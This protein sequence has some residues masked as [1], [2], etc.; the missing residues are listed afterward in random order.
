M[1]GRFYQPVSFCTFVLT[2][3]LKCAIKCQTKIPKGRQHT[4]FSKKLKNMKNF[5]LCP[6]FQASFQQEEL[7]GRCILHYTFQEAINHRQAYLQSFNWSQSQPQNHCAS[8]S[9]SQAALLSEQKYP[10]WRYLQVVIVKSWLKLKKTE[11]QELL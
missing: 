3:T 7:K 8:F 4:H 2:K 5:F 10:T 1:R 11:C 9:N 6:I